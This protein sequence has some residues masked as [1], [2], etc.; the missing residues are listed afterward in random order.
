MTVA[1]YRMA[2]DA[3]REVTQ[4]DADATNWGAVVER[5]LGPVVTDADRERRRGDALALAA[6]ALRAAGVDQLPE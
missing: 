3:G 4:R 2:P 1:R 6:A 5:L